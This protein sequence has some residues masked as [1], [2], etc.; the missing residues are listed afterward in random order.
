MGGTGILV[1]YRVEIRPLTRDLVGTREQSGS[2]LVQI[3]ISLPYFVVETKVDVCTER[4]DCG[5]G[6]LSFVPLMPTHVSRIR[7]EGV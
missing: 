3:G 2:F 4:S 6:V 7:R 1:R 5:Q